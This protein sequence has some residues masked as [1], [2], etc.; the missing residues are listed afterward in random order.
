M[1]TLRTLLVALCLGAYIVVVGP[2]ALLAAWLSGSARP[3]YGVG[4]PG[5]RLALRLAGIRVRVSGR[6]RLEPA[7]SYVFM[8]NH[9][10]NLDP[11][12]V[13]LALD[14]DVRMMAKAPLF[15]LPLLG[16]ALALAG[17]VP[18]VRDDRGR[19]VQ[20]VET[21]A[22]Q[23]RAGQDFVIFPEGTR[24]R[25]G[26]LLPLKKGPFYL[27][28]DAGVP[29]V[30][31]AIHGTAG[32]LPKGS[33]RI[34]SGSVRVEILEPIPVEGQGGQVREQLRGRVRE[35]LEQRLSGGH[36]A[37]RVDHGTD[38]HRHAAS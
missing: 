31:V 34:L 20:A 9:T 26:D 14:R 19:A 36:A 22:R 29:V 2:P 4:R 13:L 28:V 35:V 27:A 7:E 24:S 12:I 8:P 10:S 6:E 37:G 3:L 21:A 30:P 38:G 17:F 15:R 25:D 23:V 16:R 33:R 5:V 18:V 11:P 32:L 1:A